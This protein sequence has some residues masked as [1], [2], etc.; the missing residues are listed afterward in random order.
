MKHFLKCIFLTLLLV[1]SRQAF[2]TTLHDHFSQKNEP[3][4]LEISPGLTNGSEYGIKS[5]NIFF[6]NI[7][8]FKLRLF[9]LIRYSFHEKKLNTINQ[10]VFGYY[11]NQ[12]ITSIK[13]QHTGLPILLRKITI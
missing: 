4:E 7:L 8:N 3:V 2:S 13:I 1:G 10:I 11:I 12:T 5:E 9:K 6:S